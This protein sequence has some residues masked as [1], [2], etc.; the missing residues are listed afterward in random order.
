[1]VKINKNKLNLYEEEKIFKMVFYLL[2]DILGK[3]TFKKYYHSQGKRKGPVRESIFEAIIPGVANNI[4]YY[5]KHKDELIEKINSLFLEDSKFEKVLAPNP[6][7]IERMKKLLLIS[8]EHFKIN[9]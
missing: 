3:E 9:D 6:K 5:S 2:N 7:A 8:K 1:M 4:D